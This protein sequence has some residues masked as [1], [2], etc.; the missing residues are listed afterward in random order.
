MKAERFF[1]CYQVKVFLNCSL[2]RF[3]SFWTSLESMVPC[4]NCSHVHPQPAA[5][6]FPP[7]YF[8]KPQAWLF[9][10]SAYSSP[11]REWSSVSGEKCILMLTGPILNMWLQT[12]CE[13]SAPPAVLLHFPTLLSLLLR[14]Q[15]YNFFFLILLAFHLFLHSYRVILFL[16]FFYFFLLWKQKFSEENFSH[17]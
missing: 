12:S 6:P 4:L 7:Q 1:D 5:L 9:Q 3:I 17:N 14:Q 15:L 8:E 11:E 2:F 10:L 13:A 16:L